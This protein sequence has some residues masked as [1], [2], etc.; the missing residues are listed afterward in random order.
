M[1]YIYNESFARIGRI[2]SDGYMYTE[3][4]SRAG[5]IR[6][7]GYIFNESGKHIGRIESDGYI[8]D[9]MHKRLGRIDKDGYVYKES[10]QRIGRVEKDF[11]DRAYRTKSTEDNKDYYTNSNTHSAQSSHSNFTYSHGT[12]NILRGLTY[13]NGLIGIFSAFFFGKF[14]RTIDYSWFVTI[15]ASLIFCLAVSASLEISVHIV[16]NVNQGKKATKGEKG[17]IFLL[18]VFLILLFIIL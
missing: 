12:P 3:A 7:D 5:R 9:S 2:D 18:I 14:L 4:G 1:A 6:Q 15:I 16:R 11:I 8:Y 17:E 13:L 10:G